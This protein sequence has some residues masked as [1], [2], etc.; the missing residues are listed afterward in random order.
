ME[1]TDKASVKEELTA[2][3]PD[4]VSL[5]A[6][7]AVGDPFMIVKGKDEPEDE[8]K[9]PFYVR[10]SVQNY[11]SA[12]YKRIT[13]LTKAIADIETIDENTS[14]VPQVFAD[15]ITKIREELLAPLDSEIR[16]E[17]SVVS[18][19]ERWQAI[20]KSVL[21][22]SLRDSITKI[23]VGVSEKVMA[24]T[25]L[26]EDDSNDCL[27]RLA[28]SIYSAEYD[29]RSL[30]EVAF[31][32]R[33]LN[34]EYLD[35]EVKKAKW[36]AAYIND[37]PD[38]AFLYIESGGKKDDEKKTAP[39]SLRH[40][41]YRD[42]N[43]KMDIPHL[44][45]AIARIPQSKFGLTDDQ[46]KA[47]QDK[48]RKLL[49]QANNTTSVK[50]TVAESEETVDNVEKAAKIFSGGQTKRFRSLQKQMETL[51]ETG[52]EIVK[53]MTGI[54]GEDGS[55]EPVV[56]GKTEMGEENKVTEVISPEQGSAVKVAKAAEPVVPS[57][58]DLVSLVSKSVA[59]E[60]RGALV[61]AMAEIKK[62]ADESAKKLEEVS[63]RLEKLESAPENSQAADL[64]VKKAKGQEEN[65]FKSLFKNVREVAAE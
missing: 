47:L 19:S 1:H 18:E 10:K 11:Y 56:K 50:K 3:K 55:S 58:E 25:A 60:F 14:D 32:F 37:L 54:L 63:K 15:E 31:T 46:K 51:V 43:G 34:E 23:L 5:V 35:D 8:I 48:A 62:S 24:L 9:L 33:R 27:E 64:A 7:G 22:T 39:R 53:G 57:T 41:P 6:E 52:S 29:L 12:L 61:E 49:A 26:L 45:N 13:F 42:K 2:F 59:V 16:I 4:R 36:T 40:F 28:Y 21:S 30:A 17:K 20:E 44:Q 38:D 65:V